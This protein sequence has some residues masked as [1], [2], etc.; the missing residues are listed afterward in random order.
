MKDDIKLLRRI[1]REEGIPR[2]LWPEFGRYV[3]RC[4]RAGVYGS[5]PGGHAT[6]AELRQMADDFKQGMR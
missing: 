3:E 1:A 6:E 4:K 5:G 2:R